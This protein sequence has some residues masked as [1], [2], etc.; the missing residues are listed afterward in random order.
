LRSVGLAHIMMQAGMFVSA[1]S[2][3]S[4]VSDGVF[5][6]YKR[7]EDTNMESGKWDEELGRMSAIVDTLRPNALVLFN[8]SFASTNEREGSEIAGNIVKALLDSHVKVLFVT[9]LY[10]FAADLCARK[11]RSAAFLRA[12]RKSDGNRTFKLI[13]AEPLETSYGVDLYKTIFG[14]SDAAEEN[15]MNMA[16]VSAGLA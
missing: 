7:E 16:R 5:T 9:H 10:H 4:E 3:A 2:F 1:K 11:P 12:E 15:S 14:K 6:H 13:E 8:E